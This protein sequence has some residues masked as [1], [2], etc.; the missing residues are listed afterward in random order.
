MCRVLIPYV[1][2]RSG[3]LSFSLITL[4]F[5]FLSYFSCSLV[6]ESMR[7][8]PGNFK[9]KQRNQDFE[10]LLSAHMTSKS[11]AVIL[12]KHLYLVQLICFSSIGIIIS[13]Y[14]CDNL[15]EAI[16][17]R[18]YALQVLPQFEIL[19]EINSGT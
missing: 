9:L 1:V 2:K 16:F 4:A 17:G 12:S 15:F 10:S 11:L 7:L 13:T 19:S 8:V 14:T 18:T 5:S 3:W 6:Y